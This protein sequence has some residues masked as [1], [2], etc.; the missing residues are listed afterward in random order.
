MSQ[1][2]L[3][4]TVKEKNQYSKVID[5]SFNQLTFKSAPAPALPA[6]TSIENFFKSY[7]ELFYDIP[8]F[9]ETNSHEYLIK[10]SSAYIGFQQENEDIQALLDEIASL[11]QENLD[12][13]KQQLPSS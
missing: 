2:S 9:G 11:R 6:E 4:K 1:I 7:S 8:E 10:Q 13:L 12:L 3:N 5:T